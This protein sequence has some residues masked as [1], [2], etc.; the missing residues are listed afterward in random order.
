[1]SDGSLIKRE[2]IMV[3]QNGVT[4]V[5]EEGRISFTQPREARWERHVVRDSVHFK[6]PRT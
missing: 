4:T 3:V 1:M 2:Q 6:P 5:L